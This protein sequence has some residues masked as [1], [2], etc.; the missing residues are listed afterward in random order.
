LSQII[1]AF[2]LQNDP[3]VIGGRMIMSRYFFSGRNNPIYTIAAVIL[4]KQ[5]FSC[6]LR[7]LAV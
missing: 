4:V 5:I 6:L 7:G 2:A 1:V 3:N